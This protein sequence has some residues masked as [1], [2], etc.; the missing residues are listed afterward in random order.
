[1]ISALHIPT[2]AIQDVVFVEVLL[3]LTVQFALLMHQWMNWASEYVTKDMMEK[4]D[5]CT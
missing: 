1:M 2:V 4:I 5:L 3:H